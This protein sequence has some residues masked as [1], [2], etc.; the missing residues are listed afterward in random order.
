MFH[1]LPFREEYVDDPAWL[2]SERYQRW[3]QQVP[4]LPQ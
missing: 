4:D 3:R 2:V 1:F